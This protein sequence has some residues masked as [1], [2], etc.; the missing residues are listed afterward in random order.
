MNILNK[1]FITGLALSSLL[2]VSCGDDSEDLTPSEPEKNVFMVDPS[3]TD[4]EAMIRKDFYETTGIHLI[5]TDSLIHSDGSLEMLDFN[6]GFNTESS[7]TY[8]FTYIT[9]KKEM[10]QSAELLS[11]YFV[12]Y[13]SGG[14][15]R[16]F[17]MLPFKKIELGKWNK[18]KQDYKW[19]SIDYISNWRCF[20]VNTED[21]AEL[22]PDEYKEAGRGLLTNFIDANLNHKSPELADF[23][24]ICKEYYFEDIDEDWFEE[25]DMSEI[26]ALGFLSYDDYWEGYLGEEDDF[27]DFKDLVLNYT[28]DEV[29]EMYGKYDLIMKKYQLFKQAIADIGINLNAD[30]K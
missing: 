27:D 23:F 8:R 26:Y 18:K 29:Y 9:D 21:W 13:I 11:R 22:E 4:D 6:W 1:F 30:I 17:S 20:A 10:E 2:V 28:E 3:R 24:V 7:D 5:F 14:K 12:P 16:P 19:S 25:E 15:L